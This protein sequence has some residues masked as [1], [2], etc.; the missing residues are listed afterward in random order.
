MESG[1]PDERALYPLP[2]ALY[3]AHILH[4]TNWTWDELMRTPHHIVWQ[5]LLIQGVNAERQE[6]RQSA[7]DA[8]RAFA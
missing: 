8:S 4:I 1:D 7:M 6:E 3:Q 2:P 5:F